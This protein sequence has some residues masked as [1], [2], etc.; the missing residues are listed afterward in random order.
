MTNMIIAPNSSL[1]AHEWSPSFPFGLGSGS[2]SGSGMETSKDFPSPFPRPALSAATT[3]TTTTISPALEEGQADE[4]STVHHSHLLGPID[5]VLHH[6]HECRIFRRAHQ[7]P[8][9]LVPTDS[10]FNID[11]PISTM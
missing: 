1:N 11:P 8:V 9:H 7:R 5:V 2:G 3:T 6:Q 10:A 4:R